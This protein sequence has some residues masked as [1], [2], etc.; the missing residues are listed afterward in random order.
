MDL[1]LVPPL[2]PFNYVKW[3]L[4]IVLYIESHDLLDVSFRVGKEYYEEENDQLN[5]RDKTYV[6]MGMVMT[7]NMRYLM[8]HVEYPFKLKRNLDRAFGVGKEVENTWS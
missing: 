5:D 6:S 3:K 8:E 7:P 2:S 4:N 1:K